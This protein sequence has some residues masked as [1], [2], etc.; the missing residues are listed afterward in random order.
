MGTEV[1]ECE[2]CGDAAATRLISFHQEGGIGNW[3]CDECA[4]EGIEDFDG[5]DVTP[6]VDQP[7]T[8]DT[9]PKDAIG[10]AKVPLWSVWPLR[11]ASEVALALFEGA[12]KY[13]RH[14]YRI[15]GVRASVYLDATGRHLA[16][17]WEG[18]DVDPDSGLSHITKAIASLVVLRDGM[19][20]GNWV[21]DRPPRIADGWVKE[22][23]EKAKQIIERYPNAPAPYT[24]KKEAA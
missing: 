20:Q 22:M 18:E 24:E 11:V 23:N 3:E 19:M 16:A 1:K 4:A 7:D 9:N 21:D 10:I 17:F 2:I 14:N 15:A 6:C 8:K 13:A 12:R 5:I